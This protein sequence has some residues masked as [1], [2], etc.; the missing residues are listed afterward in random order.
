[1]AKDKLQELVRYVRAYGYDGY[2]GKRVFRCLAIEGWKYWT[3]W[4]CVPE[5]V[6]ESM[7]INRAKVKGHPRWIR[8]PEGTGWIENPDWRPD[9][10][11]ERHLT[12]NY[13]PRRN[14]C[15]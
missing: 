10:G 7:G 11:S 6:E 3:S 1:M 4:P 2:F 13:T 14:S 5:T 9:E 15:E 8:G 12:Q